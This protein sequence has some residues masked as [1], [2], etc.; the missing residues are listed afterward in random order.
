MAIA[1]TSLASIAT[2]PLVEQ[3]DLLV[4]PVDVDQAPAFADPC[5]RCEFGVAEEDAD[6]GRRMK[7]LVPCAHVAGERCAHRS[8]VA[9]V[10]AFYTVDLAVVQQPLRAVDPTAS[11]RQVAAVQQGESQPEGAPDRPC[12]VADMGTLLVR[13]DPGGAALVAE[14]GEIR[15]G[16]QP[17]Q[18]VDLKRLHDGGRG[19][20][21]VRPP[22]GLSVERVAPP[23][24]RRATHPGHDTRGV[25]TSTWPST[26]T[27]TWPQTGTFSWPRTR[28]CIVVHRL[29][30][31]AGRRDGHLR[32]RDELRHELL[33]AH[34]LRLP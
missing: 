5:Q 12:N 32:R 34:L 29:C 16:R 23:S 28:I 21:V 31:R 9:Q 11:A 26:G 6:L 7:R 14:S 22:P 27:Y 8:R 17:L 19:Q 2:T 15:R 33:A 24:P 13:V 4:H 1:E 10:T 30:R 25:E 18:I 3:R 20:L